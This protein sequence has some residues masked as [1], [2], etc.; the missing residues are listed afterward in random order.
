[1]SQIPPPRDSHVAAINTSHCKME[2]PTSERMFVLET[3]LDDCTPEH[4]AYCMEVLL[5]EGAADAWITPIVMKK[6]R[7]A[8]TLHCLCRDKL[9][10][11]RLLF[12]HGP[13]LGM[14]IR[15][16]ER[17]A[18]PRR[19]MQVEYQGHVVKVKVGYLDG[20]MVSAKPEFDDCKRIAGE[21]GIPIKQISDQV[22]HLARDKQQ[23]SMNR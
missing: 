12:Q 6:G 13:T 20:A 9:K 18:L 16:V 14:R 3:N 22:L 23:D 5:Q 8:H 2:E 17:I 15:E 7:A 11:S 4:L 10:F 21:L 1:M 19:M